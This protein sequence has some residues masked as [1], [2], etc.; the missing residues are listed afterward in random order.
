V[1]V[2]VALGAVAFVA[3]PAF[4]GFKKVLDHTAVESSIKK[5]GGYAS[6]NCN[7][8]KNPKVKAGA[9]FTCA[10][11]GGKTITVTIRDSKGA[12]TWTPSS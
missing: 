10:V 7:D 11:D 3:K 2:V 6:V 12:Y 1:V 4:L 9:K 5:Q 8:G